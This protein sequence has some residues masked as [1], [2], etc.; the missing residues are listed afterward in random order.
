MV[1]LGRWELHAGKN[2]ELL[3]DILQDP[4]ATTNL[5]NE[6]PE[7]VSRLRASFEG[8]IRPAGDEEI[9]AEERADPDLLCE[10]RA[11]GYLD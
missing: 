1:R 8:R 3:F 7:I 6:R 4:R 10:L 5:A 2:E 9:S 11:G